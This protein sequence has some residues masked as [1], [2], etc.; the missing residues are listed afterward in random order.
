[1]NLTIRK[2]LIFAFLASTIIPILCLCL[3]LGNSIRKDLLENF[4]DA[5]GNEL[6][7]IEN[8]I[9]IF[10]DDIKENAVMASSHEDVVMIDDTI[11]SF[12]NETSE[13]GVQDFE[14]SPL[15]KRVLSFFHTIK[16]THKSYVEVFLGTELGGFTIASDMKLPAGYDPRGRPWYKEAKANQGKPLI[17][18]AYKSTTGDAVVSATRTIL[19]DGKM[20]GVVGFDVTLNALTDFIKGI[21]IGNSGYVILI[22]DDGVILADPGHADTAFKK[23][24]DTGIPAF[25]EIQKKEAGN[26]D[27]ELDG[28]QYIAKV[29]TSPALG[30]KLVGLIKKSEIMSKVWALISIMVVIGLILA[31][32]FAVMALFLAASLA[33]P[34]INTTA[35]IKD[36]AQGEGDLTKRL[37]V[38]TKDE[39]GELARWF[40]LFLDNLQTIIKDLAAN[41]AVVDDSS[42]KLLD[43]SKQME[44]GAKES[45]LL[46]NT[47]ASASEEMSSNMEAVASTMED[48]THNTNVVATATEEMTATINEIA[49]N[50][51]T[52][53]GISEKAV[54]QMKAASTKMDTLGKAAESIGA[55]TETISNISDQTNL[56]ALNATIEAARAGE[57]GKGFAV[58]ANEIKDLA[59]Q[60]AAATA[61]IRTQIEGV[62]T[63]SQD[64]VSEIQATAGVMD[65]INNII[66]T[67][68]TAIEEQSA[69]TSEISANVGQVSQGI[70]EVNRN[71]SESSTAI[72]EITRDITS[73]DSAAQEMSDNSSQVAG[74]VEELKQM[75]I[76]LNQIVG[77]FKY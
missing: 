3:I 34:L 39:L 42:A 7:R 6:S 36:I 48:T 52:A 53:R 2:K 11:T 43:V 17:T 37:E 44:D 15:E 35:M 66:T 24:D 41:V 59:S 75:A 13:K 8:A 51:E 47:V 55:V 57:A 25:S 60:T 67:I 27:F 62:Q 58:V 45:S 16:K 63:T 64:T 4:Y 65:D 68:A 30:W 28:T 61:D 73:V 26:L 20:V 12:I 38:S 29:M 72:G 32:L 5:T 23:L 33:K 54:S 40:N 49:K 76:K 56:L 71:V 14:T 22:Q 50:S 77:R 46:A 9:G 69:A 74:S 18:K 70:Q 19:R 21:K 10:L 31:A 1:M